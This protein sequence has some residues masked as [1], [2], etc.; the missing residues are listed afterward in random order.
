MNRRL[1]L[2]ILMVAGFLVMVIFYGPTDNWTWDPSF[3][4]AQIRSPIIENNLD[5]RNETNTSSIVTPITVTGLQGSAWPIGPSLLWS[6]FF[7][8]AHLLV[9]ITIPAKANGLSTPYIAL[10]S[11]GSAIYGLAGLLVLY[12][13]CRN[14]GE[15]YVSIIAVLLSLAATPLF[16]YIFH[17]PIMA[18]TTSF[19]VA[20]IL[21]LYY[22]MLTKNQI[23]GK[24]SGLIFG[25][26]IGLSF[27]MR[28]SGIF[29]II[30][31]I[32]FYMNQ[33]IGSVRAKDIHELRR[34]VIQIFIAMTAFVVTISPQLSLW[35]RLYGNFLTIPQ[36]SATFVGSILPINL[37]K[38]FFDTNRGLL[39]WSPFI[40]IGMVGIIRIPEQQ[41]RLSTIIC[42]VSQV[43]LIG[44]RVD[45]FSGGG[46]GARYFI[47]L[48]PMIAVGFICLMTGFSLKPIGQVILASLAII[49][50]AHQSVLLYAVEQ[51]INGWLNFVN[52]LKGNPLGERWQLNSLI[53][54][55]KNP[56]L[57]FAP[58]PFTSIYRQTILVSLLAGVRD[59][60]AY[61]ISGSA[62]VLTPLIIFLA[63]WI[64]KY[65]HDVLLLVIPIGVALYMAAWAVYLMLVG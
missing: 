3:Y 1:V 64:R 52:Y 35:Q 13:I 26:L 8:L 61:I 48:L 54:L 59:Y 44:Y 23:S 57:W 7:L 30:F 22:I 51:S 29:F 36:D 45:W 47:E 24:W 62:A 38:V 17:Q 25:V 20:A 60:R 46:F 56:G 16:F 58:R 32:L 42:L 28:W 14:Y 63:Y 27:L 40:L 12:K 37:F 33:I 31:P 50:I 15:K 6:P 49:L 2:L 18:H 65:K 34:L 21:Y 4:Y 5:F 41:I 19:F 55:A 39:F 9:L 10:V 43:I 11:F 53:K